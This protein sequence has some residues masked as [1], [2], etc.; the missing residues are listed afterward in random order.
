MQAMKIHIMTYHTSCERDLI[1]GMRMANPQCYNTI[2]TF[3]IVP[4]RSITTGRSKF[5]VCIYQPGWYFIE[6]TVV[7]TRHIFTWRELDIF[8]T[9]KSINI[10]VFTMF[11]NLK[12]FLILGQCH[13]RTGVSHIHTIHGYGVCCVWICS[14]HQRLKMLVKH[15]IS[16]TFMVRSINVTFEYALQLLSIFW[17]LS[18]AIIQC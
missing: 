1:R 7:G 12:D 3:F 2:S 13:F 14:W 15:C 8:P 18:H 17:Y 9:G 5:H 11:T 4:P 16:S 10:T 6:H